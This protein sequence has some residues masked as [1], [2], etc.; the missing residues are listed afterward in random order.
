MDDT[1]TNGKEGRQSQ[2][3]E[4]GG[5]G[6]KECH[7]GTR[8]VEKKTPKRLS[9][10]ALNLNVL[11]RFWSKVRKA[12]GCWEWTASKTHGYGQISLHG[13]GIHPVKAHRLSYAIANG[14]FD[15]SLEICHRCDNPACVRPDH[16]FAGS[17]LENM[18]DAKSK[19]RLKIKSK[20][21]R[22]SLNNSA[23]LQEHQVVE[24]VRLSLIGKSQSKIAAL[25]NVDRS[26][27]S[28]IQRGK[29]W[30][31]LTSTLNHQ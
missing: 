8:G 5:S 2:I 10:L 14:Y 17:H 9:E 13:R 18:L 31:H 29:K 4:E 26:L 15:E 19:G 21:K 7:K 12:D 20:G 3:R 23:K 6:Q 1:K 30:A 16:L 11:K 27:I 22:G 28:L 24:I 25:F